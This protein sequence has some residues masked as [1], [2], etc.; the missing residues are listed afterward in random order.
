MCAAPHL[1]EAD[2]IMW[3]LSARRLKSLRIS[4]P[5]F[6]RHRVPVASPASQQSE[7]KIYHRRIE[8]TDYFPF[9]KTFENILDFPF[10][11][12]AERKKKK[13]AAA[14]SDARTCTCRAWLVSNIAQA[15]WLRI[16]LQSM[17]ERC[18]RHWA[19][20]CDDSVVHRHRCRRPDRVPYSWNR[21]T[22][23]TSTCM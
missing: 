21:G 12:F 20:S 17:A 7:R 4:W 18:N 5:T 6:N 22:Y 13:L 10:L 9:C 3:I 23:R 2:P 16:D 8:L 11:N 1:Y 15:G 14:D 19:M